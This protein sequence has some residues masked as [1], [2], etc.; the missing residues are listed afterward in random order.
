MLLVF[1]NC[2]TKWC[3]LMAFSN[4][5]WVG[6]PVLFCLSL[7]TVPVCT[8]PSHS[9][10][11]APSAFMY[12]IGPLHL[13]LCFLSF[14]FLLPHIHLN[15]H[16]NSPFPERNGTVGE[17]N[18]KCIQQDAGI[19]RV[20]SWIGE[21]RSGLQYY[22]S[23]LTLEITEKELAKEFLNVPTEFISP[24]K[25]WRRCLGELTN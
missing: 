10:H 7:P 20:P 22:V 3:S 9:Q 4:I 12:S 14:H 2:H 5:L 19:A 8:L 18:R 15:S 23:S 24:R 1:Q 6:P 16:G 11:P 25:W 13:S 21:E 17:Q